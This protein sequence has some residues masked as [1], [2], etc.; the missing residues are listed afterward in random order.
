M[1]SELAWKSLE[2]NGCIVKGL[3]Q[4]SQDGPR[5]LDWAGE[6]CSHGKNVTGQLKYYE[7]RQALEGESFMEQLRRQLYDNLSFASNRMIEEEGVEPVQAE[8][9]ADTGAHKLLL[10]QIEDMMQLYQDASG[11]WSDEDFWY[12][13]M[14][15]NTRSEKMGF[16]HD[17]SYKM[18]LLCTFVG[19]GIVLASNDAVDWSAYEG[20]PA[21]DMTPTEWN[22]S[23][24]STE[25]STSAG[26]IVLMRG[27]K[28]EASKPCVYRLPSSA[29]WPRERLVITIE[30]IPAE[31]KGT[32][33]GLK[34]NEKL[35]VTL[36]S[37][38]LGA[39]KT[40]LLT[41][42][43]NNREGLRVAV[44]VNDMAAINVDGQLLKDGVKLHDHKDKM[45]ELQNGCICCTL[46]EDLMDSVRDLALERRFDYLLVESTGISEPMP[47]ASTFTATDDMGLQRL[48]RF[49][50]LDT[51]VTVIDCLHFLKDYQSHEKAVDRKE[52]GAEEGD[53]RCIVNL[54]IDQVEFANVLILNKTDLV[55]S[56]E[57]DTLKTILQ[58]LNPGA[59]VIESQFG[60]V[61]PSSVL[62]TR[63]FDQGAAKTIHLFESRGFLGTPEKQEAS[64]ML[65]GWIRELQSHGGHTPETEEYGIS[66]FIYSARRPFHPHRLDS[67]VKDGTATRGVVRSKGL[68][69]TAAN[70]FYAKE[71]SQAGSSMALKFG[72]RWLDWRDLPADAKHGNR[73]WGD[74]RQELV[75]IGQNMK[76]A[77]IRTALDEALLSDEEFTLFALVLGFDEGQEEPRE[78]AAKKA[79]GQY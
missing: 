11:D 49:A 64:G 2:R 58:K 7:G 25:Q 12:V 21:E 22:R 72:R 50:R 56:T 52:L 10:Q 46:Q 39:G 67:L 44:L 20:G 34:D 5:L 32:L 74:R 17:D 28:S 3:V 4:A 38:F 14:E 19:D 51:L 35:P 27:G 45:V 71:W 68:I 66:S 57:L 6:L 48:G 47:V 63:S 69:W 13:N 33:V 30:R 36:L 70:L 76:E 55:T 1:K 41:H 75:F 26:D 40:T 59:R 53:E 77:E 23:V 61:N 79:R 73:R 78:P 42:V 65:P 24:V 16:H 31:Q 29:E 60:V 18:R 9:V 62:K 54:L 15:I 8:I 37:G 43:L